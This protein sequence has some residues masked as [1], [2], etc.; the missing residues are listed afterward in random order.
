MLPHHD[1]PMCLCGGPMV[2]V[3]NAHFNHR[4]N[5]GDRIV[6][7]ACGKGRRGTDA[8]V[9]QATKADAAWTALKEM[10]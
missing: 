9:E 8:E 4:A 2:L 10:A 5:K 3:G 6:C 7:C 1:T